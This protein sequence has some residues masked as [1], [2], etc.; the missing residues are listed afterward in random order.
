M[1]QIHLQGIKERIW[2][3]ERAKAQSCARK[4]IRP[5]EARPVMDT[6]RL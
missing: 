6:G 2:V 1:P 5:G 4:D 3:K